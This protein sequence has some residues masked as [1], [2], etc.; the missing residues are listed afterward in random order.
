MLRKLW[1]RQSNNIL[2]APVHKSANYYLKPNDIISHHS[3]LFG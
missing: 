3:T 2:K 1:Y